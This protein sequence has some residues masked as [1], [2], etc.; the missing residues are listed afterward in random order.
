VEIDKTCKIKFDFESIIIAAGKLKPTKRNVLSELSR[1]FDPLGIISPV[2]VSMKLLFQ[3]L[4]SE[5]YDW[6]D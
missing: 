4:C 5:N 1:I 3:E 2:L 6:D